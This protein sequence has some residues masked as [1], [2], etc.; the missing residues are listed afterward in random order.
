MDA[1]G[2]NKVITVSKG[3]KLAGIAKHQLKLRGEWQA[4]PNWSIGATMVAFSDQYA[5]GN[6]NNKHK[7]V[8]AANSFDGNDYAG[9]GKVAGYAVFNLDT[10]YKFANTGW[11]LFAKLNNVFDHEYYSS[12]LLGENAFNGAG[13]TFATDAESKKELFL[14]PGAP[15]AGW[16]GVRFDFGKPKASV[17]T[18]DVD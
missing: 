1:S 13:G 10:R 9:S 14:A 11:Q 8:D 17:A 15:R 7:A 16:I 4:M 2:N 6:E 3:D 18:I 12:G 5:R